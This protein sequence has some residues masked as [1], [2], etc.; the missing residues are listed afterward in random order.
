MVLLYFCRCIF[1][2]QR[3]KTEEETQQKYALKF[4]VELRQGVAKTYVK[5]QKA[6]GNDSVS[7]A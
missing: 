6:F 4:C 5:I 7:R 3:H 2:L 1:C